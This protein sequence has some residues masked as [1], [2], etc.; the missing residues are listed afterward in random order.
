ME[1]DILYMVGNRSKTC[2][3][4]FCVA[5]MITCASL[6]QCGKTNRL[7][8]SR[9][10]NTTWPVE[11]PRRLSGTLGEIRG[12]SMHAGIDIKT[13]GRNGYR[14]NALADGNIEA[15][16]SKPW[17]YGK[18]IYLRHDDEHMS[19]Y[20][21]L[22]AFENT[23]NYLNDLVSMLHLLY[24]DQSIFFK[25]VHHSIH[26]AKGETIAYTG[27][28]GSGYPHLHLEYRDGDDYLN[29][30]TVFPTGDDNSPGVTA[31]FLCRESGNT[32]IQETM[33]QLS[34]FNSGRTDD[35]DENKVKKYTTSPA[36]LRNGGKYFL[37]ISCYDT[38]NARNPVVPYQIS[39]SSG[40]KNFFSLRFNK[41][42]KKDL[43]Y[44]SMIYDISRSSIDGKP[45]YTYFLCKRKG[46]R[47][48]CVKTGE[49]DGYF[50]SA[51]A[52]K[53]VIIRI[54]DIEGNITSVQVPLARDGKHNAGG[55][56]KGWE[57]A[58]R[59]SGKKIA[60]Q[61][62]RFSIHIPP[63]ALPVSSFLNLSS[64]HDKNTLSGIKRV[65]KGTRLFSV[66]NL[67]P[68][69][70][71]FR[72]KATITIKPPGN[73]HERVLKRM[74]ICQFYSGRRPRKLATKYDSS[75]KVFIAESRKSGYFALLMD[76]SPPSIYLPPVHEMLHHDNGITHVRVH[77]VDNLS[78]VNPYTLSCY[79]DGEK[80][81]FKYDHDRKW[82]DILAPAGENRVHHLL[83]KCPDNAGNWRVYRN[84][85]TF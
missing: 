61:N 8:A 51:D 80:A 65:S 27:E 68:G 58:G 82:I 44:S 28:S 32:T 38:V 35:G 48:P 47:A 37:K 25:P 6:L 5:C 76:Y 24:I 16:I 41:L 69:D 50:N 36:R 83:I 22:D 20:G 75:K 49:G 78:G 19:V 45:S 4:L 62:D 52:G 23:S 13:N 54:S 81:S 17:G 15:L 79:L 66:F 40:D 71:V 46:N 11:L 1:V 85:V 34:S 42:T 63:Y 31:V 59:S 14:V 84:L 53:P 33:L 9:D 39:S 3:F 26:F 10:G 55:P 57:W 77:A 30:V 56:G 64:V 73:L 29:P 21:H 70:I 72:K 74:Y 2:C 60:M 18:G 67:K 7:P 12:T 43:Y